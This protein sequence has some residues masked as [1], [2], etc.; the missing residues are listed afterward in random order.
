LVWSRIRDKTSLL[1]DLNQTIH[2][3]VP[4]KIYPAADPLY[5]NLLHES[6]RTQPKLK[7]FPEV[8][9]VASPTMDFV[10]LFQITGSYR[11]PC[12]NTVTI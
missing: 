7:S 4:N 8:A 11:H 3:N 1:H 12:A 5:P 2:W 10:N 9:L 6:P